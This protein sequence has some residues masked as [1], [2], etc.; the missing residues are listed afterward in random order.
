[1]SEGAI[2]ARLHARHHSQVARQPEVG[3]LG[4]ELVAVVCDAAQQH[5]ACTCVHMPSVVLHRGRE[6][7]CM[8]GGHLVTVLLPMSTLHTCACMCMHM[9]FLVKQSQEPGMSVMQTVYESRSRQHGSRSASACKSRIHHPGHM[10]A[11][12]IG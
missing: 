10:P 5:V 12:D 1:M 6:E 3:H 9:V 7:W 11:H 4:A 8:I 2:G